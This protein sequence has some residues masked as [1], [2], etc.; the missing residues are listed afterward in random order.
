MSTAVVEQVERQRPSRRQWRTWTRHEPGLAGLDYDRMRDEL[1]HGTAD[2]KDELLTA[3]VRLAQRNPEVV[4]VVVAC[5]LPGLRALVGRHARG[6]EKAEALAVAVAGLC[7]SI[8]HHPGGEAPFVA[9]RLL[10][11]PKRRLQRAAI[12]EDTWRR[13]GRQ[14]SER[15]GV[16][17]VR[18]ELSASALLRLAVDAGV[19]TAT[20]AWLI[21]ATRIGGHTLGWAAGRLG[22]AYE[23]AKKR[24]QRAEARWVARWTPPTSTPLTATAADR[25]AAP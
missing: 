19:L 2:R 20:D 15:A 21:H 23:T 4:A 13:H 7:E 17:V 9:N 12:L 8:A 5:L 10:Q 18:V 22:V 25:R 6:L 24:R 3:L 11:L 16:G 14:L 1:R